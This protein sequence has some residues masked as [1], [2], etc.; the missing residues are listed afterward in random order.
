MNRRG[1][2]LAVL[3]IHCTFVPCGA[4]DSHYWAQQYGTRS[5]LLGGLV[6]GDVEDLGATFYNPGHIALTENPSFLLSA[7]VYQYQKIALEDSDGTLPGLEDTDVGTAPN[8]FAGSFNIKKWPK[9]RFAYSL[10]TRQLSQYETQLRVSQEDDL[11]DI[12]PGTELLVG[13]I[14]NSQDLK[15]EWWGLS[16]SYAI[17][18]NL[19]IGVTNYL[20]IT[21]QKTSS[22]LSLEVL[23]SGATAAALRLNQFD[24]NATSLLWK[25]GVAWNISPLALGLSITTPRI[26]LGGKGDRLVEF[27]NAGG[28]IDGDEG[29]Q[30]LLI[31]DDQRDLEATIK[32]PLS[33]G[34]GA[35]Y[36]FNRGKLYFS[37]EWF[38]KVD[39]FEVLDPKAF[40]G[41]SNGITYHLPV[42]HEAKS[43]INYGFGLVYY[44]SQ[45]FSLYGSFT[46]DYSYLP[47]DY[48]GLGVYPE[49]AYD[50]YANWDLRH[51]AGGASFTIKNK[52]DI[53]LGLAY[54]YAK[55]SV[56]PI[57]DLPPDDL[58]GP[59]IG[60][61]PNTLKYRRLNL[62][63]GFSIE[64]FGFK[65]EQ[66]G[67]N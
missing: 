59:I 51:I 49:I 6:I 42:V 26:Q 48:P 63:L 7:K 65:I 62:I 67:S 43:I 21:S 39:L 44:L 36:E 17:S 20:V 33:I 13:D 22:R 46:T 2:T 5:K 12:I 41:Q 35:A 31:F 47:D 53:V 57:I 61:T 45:Q 66:Q 15:D 10:I 55:K 58:S 14:S 37:A 8:L 11:I 50:S 9:H 3:L 54:A 40:Q 25:F 34:M 28:P 52:Y 16:W 64:L 1:R 38:G 18:P 19:G 30:D 23:A 60:G 24:Y 27:F 4:Q 56:D 29:F 32:S